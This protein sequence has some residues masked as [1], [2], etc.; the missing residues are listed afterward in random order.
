[1]AVTSGVVAYQ[2]AP[3]GSGPAADRKVRVLPPGPSA[4]AEPAPAGVSPSPGPVPTPDMLLDA[5]Q[6]R[7][8]GGSREWTVVATHDNTSGDGIN[9][10][11]QQARFADPDGLATWV[12][13]FRADG[14]PRRS[15]VQTVETSRSVA[16]ARQTFDTTVQW[17]AGCQEARLQLLTAYRV[18]EI[19]EEASVLMLR[20]WERPV[21]TYTVAVARIGQITTSTVSRTVA[22]P[23]P[24]PR[25]VVQSLADSVSMLCA[26]S[27]AT[28]CPNAAPRVR[29]VPPPPAG[30]ETGLLAVVDLPPVGDID[31]PWVG[32]D[33]TPA[34]R[35]NPA[36]TTCDRAR[37]GPAGARHARSRTFLIPQA[38]LP[39]RFGLSETY[40]VFGSSRQARAFVRTMRDRLARCEDKHLA[41][42]VTATLGS[43]RGDPRHLWTWLLRTEVTAH[44]TVR[45]RLA[46][47]QVGGAVAELTFAPTETDDVSSRQFRDL[48]ARAGD[49]LRE[50][51]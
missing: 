2:P 42:H 41:T 3:T 34:L 48:A 28:A 45:F 21:T 4:T 6:V 25:Q 51:S 49:R 39:D 14:R 33:S 20:V 35:G 26:S 23:A 8:L 46:F 15:A 50:L 7:R 11:C 22:G 24:A 44:E 40:G 31:H 36:A 16:Q 27:V 17:Y 47:V 13:T 1:V 5:D 43:G 19:G 9:T 10:I 38:H 30:S 29:E 12:R 32:T 18:S 37:F